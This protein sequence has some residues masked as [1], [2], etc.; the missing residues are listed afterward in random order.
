MANWFKNFTQFSI[1]EV[2]EKDIALIEY[3]KIE[4]G[5]HIAFKLG[6][7]GTFAGSVVIAPLVNAL[8]T[9]KIQ[10]AS[11]KFGT[12]G[13]L[14]GICLAPLLEAI[15]LSDPNVTPES[16]E[17]RCYRLR[18]NKKQL[19][20]DRSCALW[21]IIGYSLKGAKGMVL[22][23]DVALV[24]TILYNQFLWDRLDP[25]MKD[26]F[27][28]KPEKNPRKHDPHVLL[29]VYWKGELQLFYGCQFCRHFG[30]VPFTE[31][32]I[33]PFEWPKHSLLLNGVH[34]TPLIIASS[35]VEKGD[36]FI[37]PWHDIP[38][39]ANQKNKIYNM[40]CE[41]PRWT[42][43]KM[44]IATKEPLNPIHQDVKKGKP[45]FVDNCFPHHGYIWNYGAL[46][47]TWENPEHMDVNT[48][49][50]G[51]NDPIDVC[52]L[53]QR[54]A[55]R[56]EVLQVKLLGVI[57]LIDEGETDWKLLAIDVNDPMAKK[58]N[59]IEDVER[60]FRGYLSATQEWF[61]V[62]KIPAGKPANAFGFGG[63]FQNREL[64][65]KVV[66]ETHQFWKT[67]R[68]FPKHKDLW[69][70]SD[71]TNISQ[72]EASKIV[73][74]TDPLSPALDVDSA[75]DKWHFLVDSL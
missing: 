21:G 11:T 41:V 5:I 8:R 54:V 56:G 1:N 33:C 74:A 38:L 62:Y 67:L 34:H 39:F 7:L 42:N 61:R 23:I 14:S 20:I 63:Q 49:A 45:R 9:A 73:N 17:D 6:E 30:H 47:Q 69:C 40:V 28:V 59:D 31:R 37:S 4:L 70:G 13:L 36:E 2:T 19:F 29:W 57:A 52:E 25:K 68:T 58:L 22:G 65:E 66:E 51:D 12:I 10:N 75:V 50:F 72:E 15:R 43:A 60:V 64:A 3:P 53:G 26:R 32:R 35:S 46:P 71:D 44:E 27:N 16:V 18:Y 48:K 55:K 24:A